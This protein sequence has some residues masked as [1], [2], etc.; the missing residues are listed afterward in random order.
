MK[1]VPILMYHSVG[2]APSGARNAG[3]YVPQAEFGKQLRTLRRFGYRGVSLSEGLPYLRGEKHG[4]VAILT[5]DDGYRDNLTHALPVLKEHGCTAT[6]FL[7]SSRLG[8]HNAW[9][10]AKTAVRKSLMTAAE[11]NDWLRGGME[12]GSHSREHPQLR[13]VS[14]ERKFDEICNSKRDLESTFDVP[15]QHFAYPYGGYDAKS[16]EA[17]KTA[18]YHSAVTSD[19]GRARVGDDPLLLRRIYVKGYRAFAR[20][21]VHLATPIY[22]RRRP[23]ELTNTA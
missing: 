2:D 9:D 1:R 22:D 13:D 15:I 18:G 5:F 14:V 20:F 3:L 11:V 8:D 19:R 16:L 6:C 21:L 12:I 17:V 7:V 23:V 10:I 4:K